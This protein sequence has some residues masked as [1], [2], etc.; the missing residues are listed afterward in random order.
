M[1]YASIKT[2]KNPNTEEYASLFIHDIKSL[3]V[4]D[5]ITISCDSSN[6]AYRTLET[7]GFTEKIGEGVKISI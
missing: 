2:Y 6:L 3:I 4:T 7:L 5:N 1:Y